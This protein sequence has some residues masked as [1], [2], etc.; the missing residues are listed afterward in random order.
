MK[1]PN[2]IIAALTIVVVA[3]LGLFIRFSSESSDKSK[4]DMTQQPDAKRNASPTS[5]PPLLEDSELANPQGVSTESN[6]VASS[7]A[8]SQSCSCSGCGVTTATTQK[9]RPA[10]QMTEAIQKNLFSKSKNS[11]VSFSLP[12][13]S[14]A[15]GIVGITRQENGKTVM[16][17]DVEIILNNAIAKTQ[18]VTFTPSNQGFVAEMDKVTFTYK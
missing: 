15:T 16:E 10:L 6:E 13:G 7:Q 11:P 9:E 18:R 17:G 1:N 3:L 5:P 4:S 12:G 8:H 2:K 14:I